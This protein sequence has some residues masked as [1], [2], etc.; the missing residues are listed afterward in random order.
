MLKK[1]KENG[2]ASKYTEN[3]GIGIIIP[4]HAPKLKP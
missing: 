2:S 1:K 3:S 4:K